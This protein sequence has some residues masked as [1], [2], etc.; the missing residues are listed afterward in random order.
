MIAARTA[1]VARCAVAVL[2]LTGCAGAGTKVTADGSQYPISLSR[3][4]RD[5]DGEI[6]PQE[7]VAK[8]GRFHHKTTQYAFF[9]SAAPV[10]DKHDIS[11]FVN[12]QVAAHGGDAIVNLRVRSQHCGL[13]LVPV[14]NWIPLWPGCVHVDIEG[15]IVKVAQ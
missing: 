10:K 2:A 7:R 6:A 8:V 14:L 13:D 1:A 11:A 9:Y 3:G 4:V 5:A 12:R 15:D